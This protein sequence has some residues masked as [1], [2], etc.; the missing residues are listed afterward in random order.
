MYFLPLHYQTSRTRG[1]F[2][3]RDT[4]CS[5]IS[6]THVI[7][8]GDILGYN[9]LQNVIMCPLCRPVKFP[10]LLIYMTK[11]MTLRISQRARVSR[12]EF[13]VHVPS[14]VLEVSLFLLGITRSESPYFAGV[15]HTCPT[16]CWP[17][18]SATR[19]FLQDYSHNP[20]WE[21]NKR[22]P[23]WCLP[24]PQPVQRETLNLPLPHSCTSPTSKTV[25]IF[26]LCTTALFT[27]HPIHR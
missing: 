23:A 11:D 8:Q 1:T 15:E 26:P 4:K 20:I 12:R 19:V 27:S 24:R 3:F 10:P 21:P 18:V 22:R 6:K 2:K 16:K 7:I 9:S 17:E 13:C 25:F 14:V 5:R